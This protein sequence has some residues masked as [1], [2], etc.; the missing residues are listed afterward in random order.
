M[1]HFQAFCLFFFFF[2]LLWGHPWYYW[3]LWN[4]F[5]ISDT[6]L[7]LLSLFGIPWGVLCLV[8]LFLGLF[9][10]ATFFFLGHLQ[11]FFS[12]LRLLY[13][14]WISFRLSVALLASA[15]LH[16]FIWGSFK[17]S[18]T[19]PA[20]GGHFCDL[21]LSQCLINFHSFSET[22]QCP[23]DVFQALYSS[24]RLFCIL[25]DTCKLFPVLPGSQNQ[26]AVLWGS[27]TPISVLLE[28]CF[29]G[30]WERTGEGSFQRCKSFKSSGLQLHWSWNRSL[31]HLL[32]IFFLVVVGVRREM[33]S[34]RHLLK[35]PLFLYH[36]S[37]NLL[38]KGESRYCI[39]ETLVQTSPGGN[40][41]LFLSVYY[42]LHNR[43]LAHRQTSPGFPHA[44]YRM[45]LLN[46]MERD[47]TRVMCAVFHAAPKNHLLG[48][49]PF[50]SCLLY[51][52]YIAQE[53][54]RGSVRLPSACTF[55][56]C[57]FVFHA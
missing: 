5:N 22:S 44:S 29:E 8:C 27:F 4:S 3:V 18:S 48:K 45:K 31:C 25:W 46:T 51:A 7:L 56:V 55:P 52:Q 54:P 11:A 32:E 37:K 10:T 34:K 50:P 24:L 26:F 35:N 30:G 33:S 36:P 40:G 41:M 49:P 47:D 14:L 57:E 1:G 43:W 2:G 19:F 21:F 17:P 9:D 39:E 20:F 42:L 23:L 38:Y 53:R 15:W 28:Y 13:V 16:C 12:S 6:F